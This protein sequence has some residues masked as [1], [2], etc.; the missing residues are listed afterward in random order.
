MTSAQVVETTTDNSP[1][2]DYT[3]PNDQNTLLHVTPGFKSFIVKNTQKS[4]QTNKK[5]NNKEASIIFARF[6]N[7]KLVLSRFE[8]LN[9]HHN[10]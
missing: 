5:Q 7:D 2:Q 3:H 4:T 8:I 1:S 9:F 6:P 10:F